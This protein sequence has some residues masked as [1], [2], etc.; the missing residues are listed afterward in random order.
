MHWDLT[1]NHTPTDYQIFENGS[2]IDDVP[3]SP[4]VLPGLDC[5][6]Q[7]TLGV[8]AH[9]G[10]GNTSQLYTTSYTTPSCNVPAFVPGVCSPSPCTTTGQFVV[11]DGTSIS[12]ADSSVAPY[13]GT[14][15]GTGSPKTLSLPFYWSRPTHLLASPAPPVILLFDDS[16]SSPAHQNWLNAAAAHG[17]VTINVLDVGG[18]GVSVY[19]FPSVFKPTVSG[20]FQCGTNSDR[21]CDSIPYVQAIINA[22]NC[23]YT[24]SGP[25]QGI[26][27]NEIYVEGGSHGGSMAQDVACDTRTAGEIHGIQTESDVFFAA[28]NS[29]TSNAGSQIS[30]PALFGPPS[31]C[32]YDCVTQAPDHNQ[33]WQWIWGTN[34]TQFTDATHCP[35]PAANGSAGPNCIA[36]GYISSAGPVW[37]FGNN[38]LAQTLFGNTAL[39]CGTSPVSQATT[40]LTSNTL[41]KTYSNC[42]NAPHPSITATQTVQITNALHIPEGPPCQAGTTEALCAYGDGILT[43]EAAMSFWASFP[44]L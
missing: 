38:Y 4:Y 1:W 16:Q 12:A 44:A 5:G 42:A 19:Q 27:P 22:I 36:N 28:T 23:P 39:G 43:A 32:N 6:T 3:L 25:C 18:T 26:N 34:D 15:C 37:V 31:P 8:K 20:S 14:V 29:T 30:C 17:F 7:F 2:Q 10:S 11:T 24:G 40:G 13:C 35:G 21:K 41:T 9:D 33:S